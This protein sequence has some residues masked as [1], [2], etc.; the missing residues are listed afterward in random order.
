M[1][2]NTF[3]KE[4]AVAVNPFVRRQTPQSRFGHFEGT[5]QELVA[6]VRDHLYLAR[7]G[8]TPGSWL[9]PV[10]PG[11]FRSTVRKARPDDV[12]RGVFA[13]RREGEEPFITPVVT[14]E[15]AQALACDIVVFEHATL[16]KDAATDAD[17]EIVSI[18]P[19]AECIDG[20]EPMPPVTMW[21]NM[22]GAIGG[23]AA[24]YSVERFLQS[25]A[26]WKDKVMIEP[27]QEGRDGEVGSA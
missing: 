16:G 27:P 15:K 17:L 25:I 26:Y 14:G 3:T 23:S 9:V 21:R 7:P 8:D 22:S 24:T 18:N 1:T 20:D 4:T 6:L 2:K 11:R 13:A 19:K 5:E 12:I 10:P